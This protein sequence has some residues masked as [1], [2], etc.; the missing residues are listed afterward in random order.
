MMSMGEGLMSALKAGPT[1]K[2]ETLS[3][4]FQRKT[5]FLFSTANIIRP[6]GKKILSRDLVVRK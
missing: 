3:N 4:L 2:G 5:N 1:Q 6:E